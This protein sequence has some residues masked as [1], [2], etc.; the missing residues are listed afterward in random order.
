[1]EIVFSK[2]YDKHFAKLRKKEKERV[3]DA[4]AKFRKNPSDG[5]LNNHSL[6]GKMKG[7]RALSVGGDLRIIFREQDGYVVVLFLDI[8]SHNQVYK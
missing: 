3:R 7:K 5:F 8:G 1:M 4:I 6:S 2:T